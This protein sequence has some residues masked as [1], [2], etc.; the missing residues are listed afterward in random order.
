MSEEVAPTDRNN[1]IFSS[2]KKYNVDTGRNAFIAA[3]QR[4]PEHLRVL[5]LKSYH[6]ILS[7]PRSFQIKVSNRAVALKTK[8]F[9]VKQRHS[10]F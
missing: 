1:D 4:T 3:V 5:I 10:F 2:D 6:S 9:S 7:I 8:L